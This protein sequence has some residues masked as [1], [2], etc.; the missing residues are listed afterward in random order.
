MNNE[1]IVNTIKS[2]CK[3]HDITIT[4]L[5]ETL[6]MSQGLISRWNKSDPSLSRII[7]IANYFNI[8][9]DELTGYKNTINDKFIEKLIL[10]TSN[11]NLIGISILIMK[12]L[13]NNTQ[14]L[15]SNK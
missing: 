8:S 10:E 15:I 14:I 13:P 3:E 5:E 9:L 2:I 11:Q 1:Q 4:K 6:G 7:N 12:Q